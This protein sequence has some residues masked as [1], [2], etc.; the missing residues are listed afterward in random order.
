MKA[1]VNIELSFSLDKVDKYDK[2]I[3]IDDLARNLAET[4]A[5]GACNAVIIDRNAKVVSCVVSYNNVIECSK[6]TAF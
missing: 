4:M 2:G 5:D 1:T 6:Y 3:D